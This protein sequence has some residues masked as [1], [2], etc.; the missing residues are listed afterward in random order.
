MSEADEI[1]PVE[2]WLTVFGAN[3]PLLDPSAR[4]M[5][6]VLKAARELRAALEEFNR[7]TAPTVTRA[8]ATAKGR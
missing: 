3:G 2:F 5:S 4:L 6:N 1:T 7:N 8:A